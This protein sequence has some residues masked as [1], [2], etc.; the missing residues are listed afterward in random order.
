MKNEGS[1]LSAKTY[2]FSYK[3]LAALLYYISIQQCTVYT[4]YDKNCS[5]FSKLD[6]D[7][8]C[9]KLSIAIM[10]RKPLSSLSLLLGQQR[11]YAVINL[12]MNITYTLKISHAYFLHHVVACIFTVGSRFAFLTKISI[13]CHKSLHQQK[14]FAYLF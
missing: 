1:A 5:L 9:L 14:V 7:I 4:T 3:T 11:D 6:K 2:S 12:Q 8:C 10:M 13:K